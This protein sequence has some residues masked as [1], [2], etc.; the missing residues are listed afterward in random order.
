VAGA[1]FFHSL[2]GLGLVFWAPWGQL[3]LSG[4]PQM[5]STSYF[6]SSSSSAMNADCGAGA[7]TKAVFD[8]SG[9]VCRSTIAPRGGGGASP[10]A[11]VFL[12]FSLGS[13]GAEHAGTVLLSN[14]ATPRIVLT[15][16][17]LMP[18][19]TPPGA[20]PPCPILVSS[21]APFHRQT[22]GGRLSPLPIAKPANLVVCSARAIGR[23][24][25]GPNVAWRQFALGGRWRHSRL[26]I[27]PV[28]YIVRRPFIERA[29]ALIEDKIEKSAPQRNEPE[30][31]IAPPRHRRDREI[32]A[33]SRPASAPSTFKTGPLPP[34][35]I[36]G[37]GW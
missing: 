6:S 13:T 33:G 2:V 14:D 15:P 26:P 36:C 29:G 19:A 18:H 12:F 25:F 1:F 30:R 35:F 32:V 17:G 5:A 27:V 20:K 10:A 11:R 3:P 28:T 4:M 23:H 8:S 24:L 9:G 7:G 22:G 34:P 37:A 21:V 16:A 31:Q